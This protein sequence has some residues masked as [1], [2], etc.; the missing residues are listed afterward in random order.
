M[1]DETIA[2]AV[3]FPELIS[4]ELTPLGM[5]R[6]KKGQILLQRYLAIPVFI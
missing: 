3:V 1:G 2:I 5:V 4:Q 6:P